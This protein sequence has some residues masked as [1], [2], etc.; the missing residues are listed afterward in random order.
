MNRGVKTLWN[1][2]SPR[3]LVEV[4]SPFSAAFLQPGANPSVQMVP[5]Y[6]WVSG[7]VQARRYPY[8]VGGMN[9]NKLS[10]PDRSLAT[11]PHQPVPLEETPIDRL[12]PGP[13][14]EQLGSAILL[15][16]NGPG[17]ACS[18]LCCIDR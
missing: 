4:I 9:F 13:R 5:V 15:E 7:F 6:N 18:P 14:V 16:F 17:A 8:L 11:I 10:N 2:T 12:R 1:V 3:C